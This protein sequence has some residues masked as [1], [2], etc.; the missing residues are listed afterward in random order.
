[1]RH[2]WPLLALAVV[3]ACNDGGDEPVSPSGA[4]FT[5]HDP[6]GDTLALS[7]AV[8]RA[9]DVLGLNTAWRGD[10]LLFTV[11]FA[12]LVYPH[13]SHTGNAVLGIV[14]FDVDDD[15]ATGQV[16]IADGFGGT[17]G[18]GAEW[19]LYLEDSLATEGT[20]RVALVNLETREVFW[21]PGRYEGSSV[22]AVIPRAMLRI[23]DGGQVRLSG[24]VGSLERVSD[25]FPNEGSIVLEV[26]ARE[27]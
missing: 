6:R 16:A 2:P 26:P 4:R 25:I 17:S 15:P 22:T 5:I 1:M 3:L 19:S 24:A 18:I 20:H 10:S 27:P 21:I 11:R 13:S 23:R 7:F 8:G 9:H 12:E 14:D